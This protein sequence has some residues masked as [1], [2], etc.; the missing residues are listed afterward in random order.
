MHLG[1]RYRLCISK[2]CGI[3]EEIGELAHI[4]ICVLH[5]LWY[6]FSIT[7]SNR[8][9]ENTVSVGYTSINF[10]REFSRK[11]AEV[12]IYLFF[13]IKWRERETY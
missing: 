2:F 6:F 4:N 11:E 1:N 3:Y 12:A 5:Y 8:I 7:E 9:K 10:D 13:W